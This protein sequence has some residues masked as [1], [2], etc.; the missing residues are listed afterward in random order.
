MPGLDAV[1]GSRE[2]ELVLVEVRPGVSEVCGVLEVE[3][4]LAAGSVLIDAPDA[5]IGVGIVLI[6]DAVLEVLDDLA[7]KRGEVVLRVRPVTAP[8]L[9]CRAAEEVGVDRVQAVRLRCRMRRRRN[10]AFC[11]RALRSTSM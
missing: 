3:Q 5:P 2:G 6:A 8:L 11:V 9:E 7:R 10:A 4:L 1:E